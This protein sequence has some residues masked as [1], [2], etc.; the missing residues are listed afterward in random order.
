MTTLQ[1]A[2]TDAPEVRI[3]VK[4]ENGYGASIIRNSG[5]YGYPKLWE[6][7]ITKDDELCYS[8]GISDGFSRTDDVMG[9]LPPGEVA[10]ILLKI[11][12]LS[13]LPALNTEDDNNGLSAAN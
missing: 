6:L 2:L 8:T 10:T 3:R 5:S 1:Q 7:A 4:Y 9:W 13:M 12:A 11:K